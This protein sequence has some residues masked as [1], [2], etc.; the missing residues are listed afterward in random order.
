MNQEDSRRRYIE[1]AAQL[2]Q[3]N[4]IEGVSARKV[5]ARAGTVGSALYK[6][7]ENV[8]ELTVYASL[9]FQEAAYDGLDAIAAEAANALDM[10]IRTEHFFARFAFQNPV[11]FN[12]LIFGRYRD[13]LADIAR[14]YYLIF[15]SGVE[16]KWRYTD[17]IVRGRS[18]EE[19]NLRLLQMCVE[20]GS[21]C[22]DETALAALNE[23]IVMLFKGFLKTMLDAPAQD[24][25]ALAQRYMTCFELL[26]KGY[27][28]A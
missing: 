6:H 7:F 14:D 15:P 20:D 22:V 9:R 16:Q 28:P 3:E 1:A 26:L 17:S 5:A 27:L 25:Q 23:T 12:N 24:P 21:L 13:R 8:E 4:G 11:L 18:F 10:Y 2:I 19:G